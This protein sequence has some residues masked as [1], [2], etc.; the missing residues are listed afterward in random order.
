ML[1][2]RAS[3]KSSATYRQSLSRASMV[4]RIHA[5]IAVRSAPVRS[6]NFMRMPD[7]RGK[8]SKYIRLLGEGAIESDLTPLLSA[9]GDGVVLGGYLSK[10]WF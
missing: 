2:L 5:S 10:T 8:G 1:F 4:T 3:L 7:V 6:A 9:K